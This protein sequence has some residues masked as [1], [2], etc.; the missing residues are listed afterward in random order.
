MLK[1]GWLRF[2]P[3]EGILLH[4]SP[5]SNIPCNGNPT[6]DVILTVRSEVV[7]LLCSHSACPSRNT[8]LKPHKYLP[9]PFFPRWAAEDFRPASSKAAIRCSSEE[10]SSSADGLLWRQNR[11]VTFCCSRDRKGAVLCALIFFLPQP[12]KTGSL[13]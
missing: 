10:V 2:R 8:W 13:Y 11:P 6:R 9:R 7:Y 5:L 1:K 12:I 4:F 3:Q